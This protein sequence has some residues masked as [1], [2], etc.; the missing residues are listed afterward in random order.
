MFHDHLS[1]DTRFAATLWA[2]IIV[3]TGG[4]QEV[5]MTM[6]MDQVFSFA[7]KNCHVLFVFKLLEA[8]HAFKP[9]CIAHFRGPARCCFVNDR[10]DVVPI[11]VL[12]RHGV[13]EFVRP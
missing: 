7:T 13:A 12:S 1:H 6:E 2:L 9:G 3:A 11:Q 10:R 5:F 4:F 8:Y